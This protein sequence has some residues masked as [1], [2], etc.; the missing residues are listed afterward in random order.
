[1]PCVTATSGLCRDAILCPRRG[2]VP[3]KLSWTHQ[4]MER[5]CNQAL[6]AAISELPQRAN[7]KDATSK[8]ARG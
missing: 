4:W 1:M 3:S 8:D 6:A 2:M 5:D 7:R